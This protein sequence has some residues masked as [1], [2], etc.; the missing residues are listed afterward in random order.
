MVKCQSFSCTQIAKIR[1]LLKFIILLSILILFFVFILPIIENDNLKETNKL[2]ETFDDI[3]NN[4]HNIYNNICSKQCCKFTQWPI[5]FNTKDPK[6]NDDDMKDYIGTN[7]S[8][9]FGE[10]GSGCLCM[11]QSDYDYLTNHGQY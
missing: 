3:I 2:H 11:K 5:S 9:N 7:F 4:N 8:C 10:S 1:L 6:L